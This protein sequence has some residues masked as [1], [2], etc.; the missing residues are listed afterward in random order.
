[1]FCARKWTLVL[2][3]GLM[4]LGLTGCTGLM[5]SNRLEGLN[6]R[7]IPKNLLEPPR[8]NKEPLDY[9]M[10]RQDAPNP[11]LLDAYDT[12]GIYIEGI[13]GKEDEPPPYLPDPLGNVPPAIGY[14]IPIR[15]DGTLVLPLLKEPVELKG[16]TVAEA[17]DI[18]REAYIKEELIQPEGFRILVTLYRPRTYQVIVIREDGGGELGRSNIERFQAR[19]NTASNERG[20][21]FILDMPAYENDVLHAL[22]ETGG[23]PGIDAKP[24]VKVLRGNFK[25]SLTNAKNRAEVLKNLGTCELAPPTD[26]PNMVIIPTR[27]APEEIPSFTQEDVILGEGDVLVVEARNRDVFYTGGLLGGAEVPLPRDYDLDVMAAIAVSGGQLGGGFR[28]GVAGNFS[29]FGSGASL[30]GSTIAPTEVTIIRE[31]PFN[32]QVP[33]KIN[34]RKA[35]ADPS[36]RILI[37]PGDVV[38]LDYTPAEVW[39]NIFLNTFPFNTLFDRLIFTR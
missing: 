19:E 21:G 35:L 15:R 30:R 25:K 39:A 37:K 32:K 23:L 28:F 33:I 22:M 2:T 34:L 6:A 17:Q 4:S 36:Q 8:S 14:P 18:I 11:Y 27:L 13:L 26:N 12:L 3:L 29:S 31:T 38:I 7:R 1:M 16:K 20:T 5:P 9:V 24:E 10:L